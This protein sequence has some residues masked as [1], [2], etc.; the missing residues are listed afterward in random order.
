MEVFSPVAALAAEG[1]GLFEEA[2]SVNSTAKTEKSISDELF[3]E[4]A[5]K[6]DQKATRNKEEVHKKTSNKAKETGKAPDLIPAKKKQQMIT[7]FLKTQE[8]M[9]INKPKKKQK[10]QKKLRL[11]KNKLQKKRQNLT[12]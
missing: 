7:S 1:G 10:L 3:N 12:K 11:K 8:K 5:T 6:A 9:I 2:R 4:S